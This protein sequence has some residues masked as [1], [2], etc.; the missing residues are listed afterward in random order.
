MGVRSVSGQDLMALASSAAGRA[1][2]SRTRIADPSKGAARAGPGFS[3]EQV[4]STNA[5]AKQEAPTQR[6]GTRLYIDQTSKQVVV[7]I[8]N[9]DNEVIKQIP[10]EELIKIAARFRELRGKLF[11]EKV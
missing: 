11:D 3:E 4:Q 9:Q 5:E 6:A 8:V 1:P 7:Q 2:A 10:P